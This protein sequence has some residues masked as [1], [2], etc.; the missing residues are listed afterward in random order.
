MY[1]C[2]CVCMYV[3]MYACT[4]A[5]VC[6]CMHTYNILFLMNDF[7]FDIPPCTCMSMYIHT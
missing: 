5:Y 6:T 3:C 1:V 2:V 7:Q 4:H